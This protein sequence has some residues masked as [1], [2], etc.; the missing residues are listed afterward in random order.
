MFTLL[1]CKFVSSCFVQILFIAEC[2]GFLGIPL[3]MYE[4]LNSRNF[5]MSFF[6]TL[7]GNTVDFGVAVIG[8]NGL[9]L[10]FYWLSSPVCLILCYIDA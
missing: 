5:L 4:S 6:L 8:R 7:E 1:G 10:V 3:I 9:S 2:A